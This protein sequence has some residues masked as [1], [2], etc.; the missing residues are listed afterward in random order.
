MTRIIRK[1]PYTFAVM[2]P[3]GQVVGNFKKL[4]EDGNRVKEMLDAG[5]GKTL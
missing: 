4:D 3:V 1:Y 5:D 2:D